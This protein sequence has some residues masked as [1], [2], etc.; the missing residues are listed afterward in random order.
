MSEV[1]TGLL[2]PFPAQICAALRV[3]IP[4]DG[5]S[6]LPMVQAKSLGLMS[7][8]SF[9]FLPISHLPAN[10]N[11]PCKDWDQF[12]PEAAQPLM[13]WPSLLTGTAA[14][15]SG[16]APLRPPSPWTFH[17][18]ITEVVLTTCQSNYVAPPLRTLSGSPLPVV[19]RDPVPRDHSDP[20]SLCSSPSGVLQFLQHA[21]HTT[22]SGPLHLL[23]PLPGI[24]R[25][26]HRLRQNR[27]MAP[28]TPAPGIRPFVN[29]LLHGGR[30][31]TFSNH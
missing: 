31:V 12:S 15:A 14:V 23:C 17:H 19:L 6:I 11:S 13:Q 4:V 20:R 21:R 16:V 1:L 7:H 24:P 10:P 3:R 22:T 28:V 25:P 5:S 8:S 18:M 26:P 27:K 2:L 30:T 29:P 9:S